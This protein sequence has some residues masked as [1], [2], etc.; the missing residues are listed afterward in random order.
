MAQHVKT[1]QQLND[2]KLLFSFFI[3]AFEGGPTLIIG[4][5]TFSSLFLVFY[6]DK[7]CRVVINSR[8]RYGLNRTE[9]QNRG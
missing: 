4:T 6:D 9:P 5:V 1:L 8:Q 7:E 2:V 3:D